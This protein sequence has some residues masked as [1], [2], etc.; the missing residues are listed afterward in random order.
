MRYLDIRDQETG[1]RTRK[2]DQEDVKDRVDGWS[3]WLSL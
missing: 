2:Q 1:S 3:L